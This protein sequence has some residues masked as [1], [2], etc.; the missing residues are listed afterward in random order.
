MTH[1]GMF[2]FV[3]I[4]IM[5]LFVMGVL[6]LGPAS[7]VVL[8]LYDH[9]YRVTATVYGAVALALYP[10][11]S[12]MF[13]RH[14]E[15]QQQAAKSAGCMGYTEGGMTDRCAEVLMTATQ[16]DGFFLVIGPALALSF[17]SLTGM[18]IYSY[19]DEIRNIGNRI[20]ST[21]GMIA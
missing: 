18:L 13:M 21:F 5:V 3:P 12:Y 16:P 17:V 9:G 6:I 15:L 10:S 4:E 1:G 20:K 2:S 11:A 19:A 7:L 8:T 14:A